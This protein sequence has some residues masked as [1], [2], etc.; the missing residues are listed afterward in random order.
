MLTCGCKRGYPCEASQG[1]APD[2]FTLTSICFGFA[3][4]RFGKK[5]QSRPSLNS[6]RILFASMNVGSVKLRRNSP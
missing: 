2:Y 6:A 4:S 5:T 1:F 3:S